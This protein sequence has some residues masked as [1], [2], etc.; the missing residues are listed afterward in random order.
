MKK[1]I[2]EVFIKEWS[3]ISTSLFFFLQP[4]VPV[5]SSALDGILGA[6]M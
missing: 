5:L 4:K 6:I 3:K 2:G 1:K